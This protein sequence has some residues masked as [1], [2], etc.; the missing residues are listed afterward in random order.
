MA[1]LLAV[2][3]GQ[4]AQIRTLLY[5][6]KDTQ[7]YGVTVGEITDRLSDLRNTLGHS[8]IVDEGI[9]VPACLGAEGKINGNTLAGDT[10]SVGY[11]R[12]PEQIFS[13]VYGSGSASQPGGFYPRGADGTIAR[14]LLSG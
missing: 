9:V 11:A 5:E 1:G 13:V 8:G 4:D 3:S 6:R 2:E 14:S 7:L 12:T 10:F